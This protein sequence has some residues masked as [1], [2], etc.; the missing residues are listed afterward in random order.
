MA[1]ADHTG[2]SK[3]DGR[4]M[5]LHHWLFDSA[6]YQ[7]LSS[8][9]RAVHMIL[10]R[11]YNGSNNGELSLSVREVADQLRISKSTAQRVFV[12]LQ[13]RGFIE[14][15]IRGTFT[16]KDRRATEWRLTQYPCDLSG[17]MPSKAFMRWEPE[18]N[19]TVSPQVRTVPLGEPIGPSSGTVHRWLSPDGT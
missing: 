9:A 6:A 19:L 1:K 15:V 7:S 18:K 10:L 17:D 11:R 14:V 13:E 3:G 12:E 16:R 2:R 8:D 4:H 5:R